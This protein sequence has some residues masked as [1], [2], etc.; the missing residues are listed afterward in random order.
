[1]RT[2]TLI[3]LLASFEASA[4]PINNQSL[5]SVADILGYKGTNITPDGKEGDHSEIVRNSAKRSKEF[6]FSK[7]EFKLA[8]D[9]EENPHKYVDWLS[10][11]GAEC[12][13]GE[14]VLNATEEH[15]CNEF[16][17]AVEKSCT[18]IQKVEVAPKYKYECLKSLNKFKKRC[19]K[20]LYIDFE[21]KDDCFN[22][23]IKHV[24]GGNVSINYPT[25]LISARYGALRGPLSRPDA[26]YHS[27]VIIDVVDQVEEV[28]LTEISYHP[29]SRIMLNDAIIVD[30]VPGKCLDS[31]TVG[32]VNHHLVG[33]VVNGYC[34]PFLRALELNKPITKATNQVFVL[35]PG[36]NVIKF[37]SFSD[38]ATTLKFQFK[39]KCQVEKDVWVEKCEEAR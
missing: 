25:M 4:V 15:I 19:L 38:A 12:K 23:Q 14:S 29:F 9:A 21:E 11:E 27:E 6:E 18:A 26:G 2:F 5:S 33:L 34:S 13:A 28:V 37:Y 32:T 20:T 39:S 24:S 10:G 16:N 1:M 36:R 31:F 7:S 22:G 30:S 17:E 3:L 8:K 35:Q